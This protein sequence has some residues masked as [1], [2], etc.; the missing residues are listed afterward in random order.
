M[1]GIEE[2]K[3]F[4]KPI[5]GDV[6]FDKVLNLYCFYIE[7]YVAYM[8]PEQFD[9]LEMRQLENFLLTNIITKQYLKPY[10]TLN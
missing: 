2:I 10:I 1:L 6:R 5:D 7:D 9:N 3:K 4:L 8:L